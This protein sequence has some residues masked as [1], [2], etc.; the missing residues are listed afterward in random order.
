[1]WGWC[2]RL[3]KTRQFNKTGMP[4]GHVYTRKISPKFKSIQMPR[5]KWV[6]LPFPL[7]TAAIVWLQG[8]RAWRHSSKEALREE[9]RQRLGEEGMATGR[10]CPPRAHQ[11]QG[12]ELHPATGHPTPGLGWK[13]YCLQGCD[14]WHGNRLPTH[15][16]GQ[17]GWPVLGL[18]ESASLGL[19]LLWL[20]SDGL[21]GALEA[22]LRGQRFGGG[23][24]QQRLEEAD[25][26]GREGGG[27]G[28]GGREGV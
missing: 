25:L 10:R 16:L 6:W 21:H 1:M 12:D 4:H 17:H 23:R 13:R 11:R 5:G 14:G 8:G 27:A 15:S 26:A 3:L 18:L 7:S 28:G 9:G 20:L 22:V 24:T 2:A 19:W